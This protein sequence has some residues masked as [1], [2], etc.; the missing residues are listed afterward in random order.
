MSAALNISADNLTVRESINPTAAGPSSHAAQTV[1]AVRSAE[2]SGGTT[3]LHVAATGSSG[4]VLVHGR[5]G[6]FELLQ[7]FEGTVD[8]IDS[9]YFVARLRDRTDAARPVE[10]ATI[11]LDEVS[12]DDLKFVVPG[13]VFYLSIGYRVHP[14]GQKERS[15]GIAFRRLPAWTRHGI[16]ESRALADEWIAEFGVEPGGLQ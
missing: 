12:S 2:D 10:V 6:R 4:R 9:N 5:Q 16:A 15:T 7:Q 1:P 3:E 14:W 11:S 13:A 8:R